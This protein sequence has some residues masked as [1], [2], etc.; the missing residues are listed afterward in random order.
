MRGD[1]TRMRSELA[2]VSAAR[3]A[4]LEEMRAFLRTSAA[5][6]RR[7]EE[8]ARAR[9]AAAESNRVRASLAWAS[10]AE[11]ARV[12][13][14]PP[15][16]PR[17]DSESE[18]PV[19]QSRLGLVFDDAPSDVGADAVRVALGLPAT[20]TTSEGDE[21]AGRRRAPHGN[22][23]DEDEDTDEEASSLGRSAVRL[24]S[25]QDGRLRAQWDAWRRETM[26][27]MER[28]AESKARAVVAARRR[29]GGASRSGGGG[30][31]AR[32]RGSGRR[33]RRRASPPPRRDWR[34]SPPPPRDARR[35]VSKISNEES[36]RKWRRL[37][38]RAR[39]DAGLAIDAPSRD[40]R[41][42]ATETVAR[43]AR[44]DALV[45]AAHAAKAA[46]NAEATTWSEPALATPG[47]TRRRDQ[48]AAA[49]VAR[50][51]SHRAMTAML[52]SRRLDDAADAVTE[53]E[54]EDDADA[55]AERCFR[56]DVLS[57]ET[58]SKENDDAFGETRD[59]GDA[60]LAE[61]TACDLVPIDVRAAAL[62]IESE[63]SADSIARA[64][65]ADAADAARALA[66]SPNP[67]SCG[68]DARVRVFRVATA[69]S[70]SLRLGGHAA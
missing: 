61:S 68:V 42:E 53:T 17:A 12:A 51:A 54:D 29:D 49:N 6:R 18:R 15:T 50:D 37:S 39:V 59:V 66:A 11:S 64:P 26:R 8:A 28:D 41:R 22:D 63:S 52:E 57:V 65:L 4:H 60:N 38:R 47:K 10:R 25:R 44:R 24:S 7:D 56:A 30:G 69:T 27:T 1:I 62:A 36:T 2:A 45:A 5:E 70:R 23:A 58:A 9:R 33:R 31:G 34:R 40:A 48:D 14:R 46:A 3:D 32:A 16:N 21:A 20:T 13:H 67:R 55:E 35:R 19:P 43:D